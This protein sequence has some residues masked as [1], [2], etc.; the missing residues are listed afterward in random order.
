MITGRWPEATH[1]RSNDMI[2]D[3]F[4]P[5]HLYRVAKGQGYRT[6]LAGKNHTFLMPTDIDFWRQ[7]GLANGRMLSD[8]PPMYYEFVRWM[9]SLHASIALEPTPF[10]VEAQYPYRIV[11][12]AIEF[13]SRSPGQPFF[14]QVGFSEPHDLE[15]VPAPYWNMF[16]PESVPDRCAGPEA[17]RWLGY[18][19]QWEYVHQESGFPTEENWRRYKS[20]Y[21]GMLRLLDDQLARLLAFMRERDLLRSTIIIYVA[22]HGG[23]LMDYGLARKGVGLPECLTRIPMVWNWLGI[24]PSGWANLHSF[25]WSISCPHFA[26]R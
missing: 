15:Q 10:P 22:D 13:M 18:R 26:K 20:N 11:S 21:L 7:Y 25:P 4:Y 24:V 17:L 5:T 6:G 3:A 9:Q 8:A 2:D 12:D 19:T 23:D 16:P 14:L 1:V